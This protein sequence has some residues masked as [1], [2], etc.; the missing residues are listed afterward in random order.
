MADG[1]VQSHRCQARVEVANASLDL[2]GVLAL[3]LEM[4][5]VP[6]TA[7]AARI[8]CRV[9]KVLS[10]PPESVATVVL[11]RLARDLREG[12]RHDD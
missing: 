1:I 2:N 10:A 12:T 7:A 9:Q 5:S 8:L 4:P 11:A 6:W 3:I